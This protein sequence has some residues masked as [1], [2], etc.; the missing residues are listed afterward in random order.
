MVPKG[1]EGLWSSNYLATS[2][3][4]LKPLIMEFMKSAAFKNNPLPVVK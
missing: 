4:S 1:S 3:L 2:F